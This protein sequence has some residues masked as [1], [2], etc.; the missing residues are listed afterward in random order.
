MTFSSVDQERRLPSLA[1]QRGDK[2]SAQIDSL[3]FNPSAVN[4]LI[5]QGD[6]LQAMN[7]LAVEGVDSVKL[8]YLDPPFNTGEDFAY[9]A[10]SLPSTAWF[11][12]LV[13]RL[14]MVRDLLGKDGSV[15]LHLDDSEQHYG[16][17]ALDQVFGREAFVTTI[18][19][20]KRTSRDNRGAFSK[21]HDYIHVYAPSGPKRWKKIRNGLPDN[22]AFANPDSDPK[23]PWRSVPLSVQ[24]GHATASQF[25][26]VISPIGA[27][28]SPPTGRCWAYSQARLQELDG[29][30]R[31]YWP[32]KGA[33]KPRL[34]RYASEISELVPTTIWLAEEVGDNAA[35]K[36]ELLRM[37]P[38]SEVFDTPKPERLIE[39]IIAIA[40]DPGDLVLDCYLGSGTTAV[41]ADRMGRRWVGI[42][43]RGSTINDVV[44]PRLSQQGITSSVC[45]AQRV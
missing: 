9:Y 38:G 22:G 4:R 26:E 43:S 16:R 10:D 37:F 25:Y 34:K 40:T 6:N 18:I 23:G 31:I 12:S 27:R 21:S 42:E 28:H 5:L 24:A 15:W 7:L 11:E 8:C 19:W 14:I 17:L 35:A 1:Q 2:L 32:R 30:G 45:A 13:S 44:L 3:H 33:G 39:R 20:Q 29:E 36:K 41:V